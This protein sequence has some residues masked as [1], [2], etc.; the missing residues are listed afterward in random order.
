M[1]S[2]T[3]IVVIVSRITVAFE[4]KTNDVGSNKDLH[5]NIVH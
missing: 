1:N 3:S 5:P 2:V 4:G